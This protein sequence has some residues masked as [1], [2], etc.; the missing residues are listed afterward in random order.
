MLT[1]PETSVKNSSHSFLFLSATH[2]AGIPQSISASPFQSFRLSVKVSST[3][4]MQCYSCLPHAIRTRFAQ[5]PPNS[6]RRRLMQ[7]VGVTLDT[8][9][10]S[11]S[12]YTTPQGDKTL[13]VYVCV[14]RWE[15]KG[16]SGGC[17]YLENFYN[18][19]QRRYRACNQMEIA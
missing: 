8:E 16:G 7:S 6:R 10:L 15:G 13:C 5:P 11:S 4:L 18:G 12:K 19:V 2:S 17:F 3:R 14:G 9:N 1:H